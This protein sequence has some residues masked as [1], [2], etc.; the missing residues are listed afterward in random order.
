[1]LNRSLLLWSI[2]IA[3]L[4]LTTPG[5]AQTNGPGGQ[6]GFVGTFSYD[7]NTAPTQF[8]SFTG[9]TVATTP[10]PTGS[11]AGLGGKSV[12][13]T[14]FS[15]SSTSVTPLWTVTSGTN[16]FYLNASITS[17]DLTLLPSVVSFEG[18]GTVFWNNNGTIESSSATWSLS[19][20]SSNGFNLQI[21][22]TKAEGQATPPQGSSPTFGNEIFSFNTGHS[23]TNSPPGICPISQ[24]VA[25][26]QR[27]VVL[28]VQDGNDYHVTGV[29]D[30]E[31]NTYSQTVYYNNTG[32]QN[33]N[34]SI[35]SAY[36]TNA[37]T[38]GTDTITI[39]WS[40]NP[41]T[42]RQYAVSIVTLNNTQPSGQPDSIAEHSA[43][44][45]TPA[46]SVPGTTV[47]ANT[48]VVGMLA[49]NDF[50]WQIGTG[51]LYENMAANIH[52]EFF[53]NVNSSA[54]AYNPGGSGDGGTYSGVWAA[55][56]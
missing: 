12:T 20:N 24:N 4:C 35:W 34:Q 9:V 56:K 36:V 32:F 22:L 51:T 15:F 3:L 21:S 26:G 40:P 46:V 49:A 8:A 47:A 1:M 39:T 25:A 17:A 27:I 52:Y 41:T 54:G 11:F 48:I 2:V 16:T 29:T 42:W 6:I 31:G 10:A 13:F 53:Y 18:D 43:Y 30:S 37:L 5:N 33:C 28:A 45:Y 19:A 23:T 14:P 38:A 50:A 7:S 55:F 44:M